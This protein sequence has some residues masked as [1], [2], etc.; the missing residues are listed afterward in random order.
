M[1][2]RSLDDSVVLVTG[3]TS[4]IGLTTAKAF[5]AKGSK[6]ALSGRRAELGEEAAQS[7]RDDGGDALFVQTDMSDEA[8]VANLVSRTVDHYGRLDIAFNNA[9][10]EGDPMAPLHEHSL[11]NYDRVFGTNVRGVLI[12]MQ[13]EVTAM[14]DAGGGAIVNN[15]SIAGLIGYPGLA[16]YCAS[17]HAVIGLTRAAAIEYGTEHITVNAVCPG[18]I[19]TEMFD[20]I[21]SNMTDEIVEH[22]RQAHPV[23]RFGTADEIAQAVLWR[24]SP[25][26]SFTT[27]IALPIDG[28]YTTQ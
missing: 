20:R 10:I 1:S 18:V 11:D 5:A 13:H 19:Y 21:E 24:A 14:L 4:G 8:Q 15:A 27:G 22:L 2:R 12:S 17:K 7:I 6:V 23:G 3:A 25:E 26:N 9:G 28:G 16:T